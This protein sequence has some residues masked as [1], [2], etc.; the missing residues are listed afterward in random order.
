MAEDDPDTDSGNGQLF[1][2]TR[3]KVLLLVI[4]LVG[5][6]GSGIVRRSLG[7]LGYNALGELVFVLGYGG[8]VFAVW[9]GW[10]RP[11]DISGPN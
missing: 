5:I 6:A 10:I 4:L 8:M 9:Y 7:E 3:D 1:A 11:M 2:L